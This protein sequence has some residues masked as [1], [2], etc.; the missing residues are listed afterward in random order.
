MKNGNIFTGNQC[1]WPWNIGFSW[2]KFP[3]NVPIIL[4]FSMFSYV[5]PF[6]HHAFGCFWMF[7][8]APF[9]CRSMRSETPGAMSTFGMEDGRLPKRFLG[10]RGDAPVWLPKSIRSNLVQHVYIW[11][12]V[13]GTMEWIMTFQLSIQLGMENHPNWRKSIIFQRGWNYQPGQEWSLPLSLSISLHVSFF[14]KTNRNEGLIC[15]MLC[16]TTAL[17]I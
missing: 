9:P 1:I 4:L 8:L 13:T 12:V 11:L 5:F 7:F 6:F 14:P 15:P 17:P 2:K 10:P 3:V 16:R